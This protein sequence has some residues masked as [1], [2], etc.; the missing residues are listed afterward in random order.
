ML[1]S[2]RFYEVEGN[3]GGASERIALSEAERITLVF[4]LVG[5]VSPPFI[6]VL[7]IWTSGLRVYGSDFVLI[8]V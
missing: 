2:R 4:P 8:V 6:G 7:A 5:H 3:G 1:L